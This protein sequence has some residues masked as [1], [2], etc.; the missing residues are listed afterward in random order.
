MSIFLWLF[1][2]NSHDAPSHPPISA[3][4]DRNIEVNLV[5]SRV[6]IPRDGSVLRQAKTQIPIMHSC[7]CS[8][9]QSL[10]QPAPGPAS[11][12]YKQAQGSKP[13][14]TTARKNEVPKSASG[15][16][17]ASNTVSKSSKTNP[18]VDT[19]MSNTSKT[20]V[21][22]VMGATGAGKSTFIKTIT[23]R[24]DVVVG[25]SLLSETS[26]IASYRFQRGGVDYVLVD[27]PGFDDTNRPDREITRSILSWL[28]A[29]SQEAA[30][31]EQQH[32]NG[33]VYLHRIVEPRMTG[34]ALR[35]TRMFRQLVGADGFANVVLATTF[36]EVLPPAVGDAREAE[37]LANADFWGAMVARGSQT[38][39][40]LNSRASALDV[41]GKF[42]GMAK[43]TPAAVDEMVSRGL[44][45][46]DTSAA[47]EQR[48]QA[49]ALQRELEA[50]KLAEQARMAQELERERR[51]QEKRIVEAKAE[52]ERRREAERQAETK[53]A[54]EARRK[55]EAERECERQ[56][57]KEKQ[58]E[59]EKRARHKREKNAREAAARQLRYQE[60]YVCGEYGGKY[61]DAC[62][63]RL[64]KYSYYYHCCFCEND[65]YNKCLGC[66]STCPQF[67]ASTDKHPVMLK[68]MSPES[69]CVVM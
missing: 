31:Q 41:L 59:L 49:D 8:E 40:L 61:C 45:A 62:S 13:A 33:I 7:Q 26:E 48:A 69:D 14:K 9:C 21:I 56:A 2:P 15:P 55:E 68:R 23:G 51:A 66:G 30:S 24:D 36:W 60:S 12:T 39:R 54:E 32:L 47:R 11:G 52:L 65:M 57:A 4:L 50:Q 28:A 19:S 29:S 53:R 5:L 38:A 67:S 25:G 1:L 17:S 16:S 42:A 43:F 64:S 46:D 3:L 22:A 35:N 20:V 44:S 10:W 37:M 58:E 34:T 27:T 18:F 6:S 63:G